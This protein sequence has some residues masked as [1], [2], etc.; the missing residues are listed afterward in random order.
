MGGGGFVVVVVCVFT[1]GLLRENIGMLRF[2]VVGWVLLG[3]GWG[4]W[5]AMG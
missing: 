4:D 5:G 2:I 3:V 1:V